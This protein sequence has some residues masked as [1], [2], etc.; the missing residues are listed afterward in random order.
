[1]S[2]RITILPETLTNKIAA[3]E[4]VERPASVIKELIE[5]ALDAG[6]TDIS[7]EINAG[8]RRRIR[9][10]DNGHGMSRE[11]ALLCLER[12]ATSKIRIDS[13]LDRILTLG[14]RGEAIPSIAS[15][16]R[17]SLA[18]RENGAQEG[19]E[20][21]VEG[22]RVRDVR[23]CGMAPGTVITVEQI[24]YNLPA[25]LKFMKSA[26]TETGHVADIIARMAVSRPDVAFSCTSD[27]R[28]LLRLLRSDLQRRLAQV[29]GRESSQHL[30]PVKGGDDY[31]RI[32]GYVSSPALVRSGTQ[33]IYTYINGRFIRDKV[34]QH[35]VMQ[36]YRGVIDRGRYPVVALFIELLP[37]EVDVNV[38]PTK[39]E[40]RFRRQSVVHD[41]IQAVVEEV[42]RGSPWLTPLS[43][44]FSTPGNA[45]GQAY[46]ERIAAAAQASLTLPQRPQ[47]RLHQAEP[48]GSTIAVP[49][50]PPE[51]DQHTTVSEPAPVFRA[52]Q[53]HPESAG[54]FSSLAVIG[55]FRSEYILCQSDSE[56]VIIDQHAA[57]ERVAYQLLKKQSRSGGIESQ[58][59]LFPETVELS[60]SEVAVAVRFS[61]DL[62]GIGFE[63]EPFGGTTIMVSAVPR[64]VVTKNPILLI[65][66]IL[67]DLERFGT[68][69]AFNDVLESLLSRIAC[70]SVIRGAHPLENRQINELLYQMDQTDFAASCPHGR[71]VSHV[72][73][74]AELQ[75][76]FKRT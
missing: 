72:V 37:G 51:G 53:T 8:G 71:P 42:L 50:A 52:E 11:D 49:T 12:H 62:A 1:M 74:L 35:A 29:V 65:R 60:F 54:Y 28:E 63:L 30:Y 18:T 44:T 66:D 41:T 25:R 48:G 14:F 38:H 75:K 58:R 68:S 21:L 16:S 17:F 23:A 57:S 9:V 46:R 45:T 26:E 33:A 61:T 4:V 24:F 34:V 2:Q 59:L 69:A 15:V 36:A 40:V 19:T 56:L 6:A 76:I 55:Q 47:Y 7:V 27:D 3:G 73:T 20:I 67:A 22:G 5:N 70:H 43:A 32:T 39:H 64:L 10:T 31:A 13:D